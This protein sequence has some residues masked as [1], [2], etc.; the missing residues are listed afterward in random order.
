MTLPFPGSAP[1]AAPV[2]DEPGHGA[3]RRVEAGGT[4]PRT[5]IVELVGPAGAGKTAVLHAIR[6]RDDTV[7][8]G[9]RIDRLHS[10]PRIP[11]H[12]LALAPLGLRLLRD[13][14]RLW[15][16]RMQHLLRLRILSASL[17][18]KRTGGYRAVVLD[19][20]PVFSLCRLRLFRD[21]SRLPDFP[22]GVW[23]RIQRS[24]SGQLDLV[25]WLDAPDPVLIH[26]IRSRPKDH[27]IKARTDQEM[28][29]FLERF[30]ETYRT[31]LAELAAS[32]GLRTIELNSAALPP[33][34][35]ALRVLA[36]LEPGG[37]QARASRQ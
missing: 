12:A 7:F 21:A 13:D 18:G 35:I 19:E 27:E 23:T 24:W 33:D 36:A 32:G 14:P 10:L 30:R 31:I 29:R 28:R 25:V 16:P 5:P 17:V 8:A 3:A 1:R 15:R 2:V 9:F 4:P 6:Q 26:R 20:G 11:G 34:E 22:A 37:P